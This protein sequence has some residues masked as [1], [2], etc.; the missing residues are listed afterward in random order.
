MS[1][2]IYNPPEYQHAHDHHQH[3]ETKLLITEKRRL[4]KKYD[5]MGSIPKTAE[6]DKILGRGGVALLGYLGIKWEQLP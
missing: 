2:L 1:K 4:S 5:F 3:Q 6:Q